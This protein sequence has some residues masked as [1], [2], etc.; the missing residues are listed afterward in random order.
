MLKDL[1][2]AIRQITAQTDLSEEVVV[3]A[4]EEAL[5]A[6]ARRVWPE[7]DVSVEIDVGKQRYTLL[8]T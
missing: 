3:E 6:A 8:R 1:Q 4:I 7:D 2:N 5:H